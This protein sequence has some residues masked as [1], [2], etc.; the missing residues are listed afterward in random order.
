MPGLINSTSHYSGI[1]W[2][3]L[4]NTQLWSLWDIRDSSDINL[5]NKTE[6]LLCIF[7]SHYLHFVHVYFRSDLIP[8]FFDNTFT[9]SFTGD[10][11]LFTESLFSEPGNFNALLTVTIKIKPF[12]T[13]GLVMFAYDE[14]VCI[15]N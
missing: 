14:Q 5:P 2:L 7:Y 4:Y 13:E 6:R 12:S 1:V 9:L 3:L 10:G 11:Y 15:I 8:F